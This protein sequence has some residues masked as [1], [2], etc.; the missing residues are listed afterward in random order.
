MYLRAGGQATGTG[1]EDWLLELLRE[2]IDQT[3]ASVFIRDRSSSSPPRSF[4]MAVVITASALHCC[5][6]KC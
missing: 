5:V 3:D 1:T 2:K 6:P 4:F